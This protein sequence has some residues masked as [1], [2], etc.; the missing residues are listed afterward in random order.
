[1]ADSYSWSL[2][3]VGIHKK[4]Q[5]CQTNQSTLSFSQC[6]NIHNIKFVDLIVLIF[7]IKVNFSKG[8]VCY[9]MSLKLSYIFINFLFVLF[10]D[11]VMSRLSSYSDVASLSAVD[12]KKQCKT[13]NVNT[14]F[15]KSA[16]VNLLCLTLGLSTCG[17]KE[18]SFLPRSTR[19]SL[20]NKQLA[21]YARLTPAYLHSLTGWTK[22]LQHLPP[23]DDGVVKKYLLDTNLLTKQQ[24]VKY[25]IQR[26]FQMKEFV[27]SIRIH[28]QPSETFIAI[29][30]QCNSS[31][32]A[33]T[34]NVKALYIIIDKITAE[35]YGAYCTCTVGYELNYKLYL[36]FCY[37]DWKITTLI[38]KVE[39][40]YF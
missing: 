15:S 34:E 3:N 38:M 39:Y 27:H 21:E 14:S 13:H 40:Y 7:W 26:P 30:A 20:S 25:K 31:Q 19:H 29:E 1:M 11:A 2:L 24:E 35:P 36:Y 32:S 8:Q 18:Y 37:V 5:W 10:T 6:L 23:L 22:E 17:G 16:R 33:A 28:C 9:F 12:L 4:I